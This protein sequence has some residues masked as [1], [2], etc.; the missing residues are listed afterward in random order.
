MPLIHE[1]LESMHG[2]AVFSML[3]L[4]SGYW[5]VAMAEESKANVFSNV[6]KFSR[7]SGLVRQV[8]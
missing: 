5:Q 7:P 6:P 1:F 8:H 2:A 3:D 4:K